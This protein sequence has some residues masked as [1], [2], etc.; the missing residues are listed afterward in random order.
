MKRAVII[1]SALCAGLLAPAAA[2]AKGQISSI[3][4]CGDSACAGV[5]LPPGAGGPEGLTMLMAGMTGPPQPGPFYR[6][7]VR[8]PGWSESLWYVPADNVVGSD[9]PNDLSWQHPAPA[10][11]AALRAA[12]QQLTPRS[13]AIAA[14]TVAGHSSSDPG[15][16]MPLLTGS[17]KPS[18]VDVNQVAARRSQW[19]PVL[20]EPVPNSPWPEISAAYDAP[21][22]TIFVSGI[23]W[24]G[25]GW[26]Q[27]PAPLGARIAGDGRLPVAANGRSWTSPVLFAVLA[28]AALSAAAAA[29]LAVRRSRRR[30]QPRPVGSA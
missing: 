18:D 6:L 8:G 29:A 24:A 23:G 20:I 27:V 26:S 11:A 13:F 5:V 30:G 9:D 19:L 4:V 21:T 17:L 1:L 10:L 14:V 12:V 28:L 16:Y 22:Q 3:K 25:A 2:Q 7:H 15:S